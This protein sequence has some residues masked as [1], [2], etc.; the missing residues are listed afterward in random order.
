MQGNKLVTTLPRGGYIVKT[1]IGQF[2]FGSPPETIKDTMVLNGVPQVFVLPSRFFNWVKG[3]SVAE[4]EFPIYYNF[5]LKKRKTY[6]VCTREQ[7]KRFARVL[8]EAIFGPRNF[9]IFLDFAD[10]IAPEAVPGLKKEL[11]YFRNNMKLSD[12]VGFVLFEDNNVTIQGVTVSVEDNGKNFAVTHKGKKLAEIPCDIKYNP[13]YDIGERLAEPFT[14]PPFGITCLGPSH[15]FDPGDNTS[16]FLLWINRRGIMI[17]PPV[18]TTEWLIDSNVSPKLTDSIIL[19]HC[20]ADHDAGTLQK[21]LEEGKIT[22]YTTQ[23][24]MNSFL[25]KYSAFTAVSPDY[26]KQLFDFVPVT[27]GKPLYI[28][29]ARFSFFYSLHSIPTIGFKME[30]G[31]KTFVYSSDHNNDPQLHKKLLDDEVINKN[32]YEELSNFPWDSDVIFHEAGIPPLHTP[33]SC[34]EALDEDTQKRTVVYHIA[35]KDFPETPHLRLA[36]F[37]IEHTIQVPVT[38]SEYEKA[39][40]VLG[41]LHYLDFFQDMPIHKAQDFL[42]IVE[43]EHYSKGTTIITKGS[44][45][46]RFYIIGSGNVTVLGDDLEKKKIYGV[47]DYF[48]EVALLTNQPRSADVVAETDILLY[49][50]KKDAF[51]DFIEGTELKRT[52]LRLSKIRDS[53]TWNV[54]STSPF[55]RVLTPS[56]KTFLESLLHK[57]EIEESGN[58]IQKGEHPEQVYI[59]RQGAVDVLKNGKVL[60]TLTR[61]DI[62]GAMSRVHRGEPSLLT[63][64]NSEPVSLYSIKKDDVITFLNYNPGLVMKLAYNF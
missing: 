19:T 3:I 61:G 41:I 20:H 33:V 15:G 18:N 26:L 54:L 30:H 2:Q 35:K 43:E 24:I 49:T 32:R 53:E 17:D 62:V 6:I 14:P 50:I 44:Y 8:R 52:L 1:P 12:L 55:F 56:Q 23:T 46:D 36:R 40:H 39:Y 31:G 7:I 59:I 57:T 11:T 21:I 29:G 16:G 60:H 27:I 51:L 58:I 63:F 47:Y 42:T 22:V 25:R 4:V 28:H 34:L 5:F 38:S 37:G 13:T 45:G 48:G 10:S 64:K 9:D